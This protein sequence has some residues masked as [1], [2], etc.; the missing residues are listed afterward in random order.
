MSLESTVS[1]LFAQG[2]VL[3]VFNRQTAKTVNVAM[4]TAGNNANFTPFNPFTTAFEDLI[5]CPQG[6]AV[7]TCAA[8]GAHWQKGPDFGNPTSTTAST[9]ANAFTSNFQVARTYRVSLGVRF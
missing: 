8:M 1:E 9:P 5:E 4:R 3:N 6:T 7:A 2:D